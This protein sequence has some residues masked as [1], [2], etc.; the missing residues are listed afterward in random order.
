MLAKTGLDIDII[1]SLKIL[2]EDPVAT[3]AATEINNM[4]QVHIQSKFDLV[5]KDLKKKMDALEKKCAKLDQ[6]VQN[7]ME[8]T[9]V[10]T[11]GTGSSIP[12]K[13][14]NGK[15]E[16][17]KVPMKSVF[18]LFVFNLFVCFWVFFHTKWAQL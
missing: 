14:R 3:A 8:N 6:T 16:R 2:N 5:A 11:L 7:V 10:V 12:S 13:Y 15:F 17:G 1:P 4:V 9:E 18:F